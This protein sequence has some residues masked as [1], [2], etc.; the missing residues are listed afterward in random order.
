MDPFTDRPRQSHGFDLRADQIVRVRAR[1][2]NAPIHGRARYAVQTFFPRVPH[3]PANFTGVVRS[4]ESVSQ[5]LKMA[6]D[7]TRARE[8]SVLKTAIDN[9]LDRIG[10]KA[11][12]AWR[13]EAGNELWLAAQF[14]AE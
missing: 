10:I 3:N 1:G 8:I 14:A 12:T 2:V 13:F 7:D 9:H 11:R 6:A 4:E 5:D